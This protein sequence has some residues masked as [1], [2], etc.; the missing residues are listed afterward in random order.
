M[1][2]LKLLLL[3]GLLTYAN[4]ALI[5]H[6]ENIVKDDK[7]MLLWQDSVDVKTKKFTFEESKKYCQNLTVDGE[8]GWNLPGFGELFSIVNTKTYNPTLSTVFKNYIPDNYWTSK[9][10]SHGS[11]EEVFVVNFLSG[12]FNREH[13]NDK[14]SVRCYKKVVN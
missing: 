12:A 10:F 5:R 1:N 7:S 4:A 13:W 3:A 6:S 2:T 8:K 9:V 14:F 11:S